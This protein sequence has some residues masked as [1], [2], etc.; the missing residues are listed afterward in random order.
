MT[1]K[2]LMMKVGDRAYLAMTDKVNAEILEL[3]KLIATEG[4]MMSSR[5]IEL[6]AKLAAKKEQ[7]E[8]LENIR[9]EIVAETREAIASK[10]ATTWGVL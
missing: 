2:E 8:D 9:L 6:M 7:L 1:A 4:P 5:N 3:R 10:K